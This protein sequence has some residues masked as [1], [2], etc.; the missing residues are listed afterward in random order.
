MIT[1]LFF[2]LQQW[3]LFLLMNLCTKH[4][5]TKL[6]AKSWSCCQQTN[7]LSSLP[8]YFLMCKC[9]YGLQY[10]NIM[11]WKFSFPHENTWYWTLTEYLLMSFVLDKINI[12]R[13]VTH[14]DW[15]YLCCLCPWDRS[16]S[17]VLIMSFHSFF[18]LHF[19]PHFSMPLYSQVNGTIDLHPSPNHLGNISL[20][21]AFSSHDS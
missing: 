12:F 16:G 8:T 9:Y 10:S 13:F 4:L 5:S 15:E 19:A 3:R 18:H 14:P 1:L 21:A 17:V 6:V 11:L 2:T 20:A 7:L